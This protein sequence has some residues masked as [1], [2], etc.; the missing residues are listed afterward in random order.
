MIFSIEKSVDYKSKPS[1]NKKKIPT[2]YVDSIPSQT[3]E[4]DLI[5]LIAFW[6]YQLYI[7]NKLQA[8]E[9]GHESK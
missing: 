6:L 8:F 3:S 9:T 1:W 4:R 2:P 7:I 5:D